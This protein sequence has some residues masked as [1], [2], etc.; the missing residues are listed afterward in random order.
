VLPTILLGVPVEMHVLDRTFG[1]WSVP[2]FWLASSGASAR[3]RR[4][5]SGPKAGQ[6]EGKGER[7]P[8]PQ[9]FIARSR[10]DELNQYHRVKR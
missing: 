10:F 3:C 2:S 6:Q 4:R 1:G 9:V 7:P 5:Q 8:P